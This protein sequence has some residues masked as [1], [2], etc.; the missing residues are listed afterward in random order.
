MQV[1]GRQSR[2]RSFARSRLAPASEPTS[3]ARTRRRSSAAGSRRRSCRHLRALPAAA[4][5]PAGDDRGRA[6]RRQEPPLR[7]AL[8]L[9][10]GPPG[11]RPLAPGPLPS[12][13]R[14]DRLLGAGRDREG[15]VRDPRDRHARRGGGQDRGGVPADDPDFAWLKARLASACR[16]RRRARLAGGVVRSL[17]PGLESWAEERETVLVFEDLH[18]ADEALLSFLEHLADW[19]E[20]VPLLLLCTARPELFERHPGFGANARNAQR[21]N[22]APLCEEETARLIGA[23]RAGGA[24]GGDA[25]GAARAGGRQPPVRGGV[26]PPAHRPGRAG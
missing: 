3:P 13:R 9:H 7:R 22:L 17:A 5:L 10:R 18:W 4:H 8:R 2:S 26:R 16:R 14:R 12:L 23:A 6:G 11:A 19:A 20:G 24:A 15:R 25:A 21:I 1:K